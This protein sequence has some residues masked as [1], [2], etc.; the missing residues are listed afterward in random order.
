MVNKSKSDIKV[1]D[2]VRVTGNS[3]SHDFEIGSVVSFSGSMHPCRF[4]SVGGEVWCLNNADWEFFDERIK[5][6]KELPDQTG[7]KSWEGHVDRQG[8][9]HDWTDSFYDEWR[10]TK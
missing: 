7:S 9:A 2:K 6:V 5:Q 3:C 4:R 8:G 10:N 1:G